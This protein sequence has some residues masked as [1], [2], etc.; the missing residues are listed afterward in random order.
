MFKRLLFGNEESKLDFKTST[1]SGIARLYT[2]PAIPTS[3][4]AYWRRYLQLFDSTSDVFSLVSVSDI[5]RAL[6]AHPENVAT[7]VRI[8]T[9]HLESLQHDPDFS[10]IQQETVSSLTAGFTNWVP[11]LGTKVV[12]KEGITVDT[13]DRT[14]EALNCCR[15]LARVLPIIMEGDHDTSCNIQADGSSN[16]SG[17]LGSD[18]FENNL[19]WTSSDDDSEDALSFAGSSSN[20]SQRRSYTSAD[21]VAKDDQEN[22]FVIAEDDDEDESRSMVDPLSV[23]SPSTPAK[24]ADEPNRPSLGDRLAR[25]VLD[26]LFYSGFT[27]PWTEEQRSLPLNT[28]VTTS[29]SHYCIWERGIGSSLDLPGTTKAHEAHRVEVLRLLLVLL[30]KSIYVPA[31]LQSTTDNHFVRSITTSMERKKVLPLLCSLINV[32]VVKVK[33]DGWLGGLASLPAD[34]VKDRLASNVEDVRHSTTMLSL[35]ILNILLDYEIPRKDGD[36]LESYPNTPALGMGSPRPALHSTPSFASVQSFKSMDVEGPTNLFRMY[37]SKLHRQADFQMLADGIFTIISQRLSPASLLS[38]SVNATDTSSA[39][40]HIPET[41]MLLWRLLS[42]N[43]RFR[44]FLLDDATRSPQLLGHLLYHAL[45]NK[46][47]AARQGIVRLSIFII[48][49]ISCDKA[50]AVQVCKAG[51]GARTKVTG[52]Q[53]WGIAAASGTTLPAMGTG[54]ASGQSQASTG[55]D[56]LIQAIYSLIASTKSTLS[57]L[58]PPLIITLTNLSPFFKSLSIL[59]SN[60]LL[61]L[62]SSFSSPNFILADEGNPRLLYYLLESFN[63]IIQH[64]FNRNT[65]FIYAL[66]RNHRQVELI[67]NFTL[68]RGIA[69]MRRMRKKA[70]VTEDSMGGTPI[71]PPPTPRTPAPEGFSFTEKEDEPHQLPPQSPN[72]PEAERA[73]ATQPTSEKARGKMRRTSNSSERTIRGLGLVEEEDEEDRLVADFDEE[74]IYYAATTIGRN[75][76]VPTQAWV[77]SWQKALPLDTLQL[78]LLELVPK[79]QDLCSTISSKSNADDR[80]LAFLREQ[81]LADVLPAASPVLP[82]QFRWTPQVT[83]WLRSYLWGII[84]LCSSLPYGLYVG[85]NARLFQIRVQTDEMVNFRKNEHLA[86]L[87]VGNMVFGGLSSVLGLRQ[88]LAPNTP[89]THSAPRVPHEA[90]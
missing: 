59:S 53:R 40:P 76:F 85:T 35:Q 17:S 1:T 68:R 26:L 49:D 67:A 63:I 80:V 39:G 61:A 33:V 89:Q 62:F 84:Y 90:Q 83:I 3:D 87:N 65:N 47:S 8:L 43:A 41:L 42:H 44:L 2:D 6:I 9:K 32:S 72:E 30:S 60:R 74:Q 7:L 69:E 38:H 28:P 21:K 31:H 46:D 18:E 5:R 52:G 23:S 55:A 64:G 13:R 4:S 15:I 16:Q 88:Q 82:R 37:L 66:V 79:V 54:N 77:T 58:Y 20:G 19:L 10:P 24:N 86:L 12:P 29:R 71:L 14:R 70:G 48:H 36:Q 81:S 25:T 56:I 34:L 78:T 51:S 11:N 57:A 27:V 73:P 50:F 22:H 45:N 75:G